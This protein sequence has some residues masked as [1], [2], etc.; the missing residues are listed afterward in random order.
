MS[1]VMKTEHPQ[2][3]ESPDAWQ[4]KVQML[5]RLPFPLPWIL[6]AGV[7]F[8]MG[9]A[10]TLFSGDNSD[11][12][13]LVAIECAL[14]AAIANSV[15]FFEKLLDDVADTFPA[16]LDEEEDRAKEW[17]SRW[18]QCIFWSKKNVV[19]GLA[20]GSLCVL[21]GASSSAAVFGSVAGKA[22]S[23]FITFLIGLLG[24]SMFWTMLGVARLTSSLGRDVRIKPSIFDSR[25]S[26]LRTASS[27]LWKVS[28][29]ASLVYLLGV[30]IYYFCSL[31]ID[32][33]I[34]AIVLIFGTFIILYFILPQINI[35][36]TL[37][38]IKRTRLKVLVQQ[39]DHTFDNVAAEP[40]PENINQLRDLFHLQD[41]VNGKRSWSFGIGELLML[42]GSVLI[43]LLLFV[44]EHFMRR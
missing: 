43:P 31:Q 7:L 28:L 4:T 20:L 21:C 12:V 32:A 26:V 30:S 10:V 11:T 25:T 14:I 39:I 16:L 34:L 33:S 23:Y 15:V 37:V 8:L 5:V 42:I 22:Y 29:T 36:K 6:I 9:Y 41:I 3:K 19:M 40:T 13:R 18:Y 27:V 17:I 24:G 35:H 1:H 2:Y 44:I 38:T